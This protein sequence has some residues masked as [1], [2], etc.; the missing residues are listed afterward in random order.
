[1]RPSRSP[2]ER[3]SV[4]QGVEERGG[5]RAVRDAL[6]RRP[7]V[8]QDVRADEARCACEEPF[9]QV[10]LLDGAEARGGSQGGSHP[11]HLYVLPVQ[12]GSRT[13][14]LRLLERRAM[15]VGPGAAAQAVG[16]LH[17]MCSPRSGGW[18]E[19]NREG[20]AGGR[21]PPLI[22]SPSRDSA[23]A[24]SQGLIRTLRAGHT[25]EGA[26]FAVATPFIRQVGGSCGFPTAG[27]PGRLGQRDG[28][29]RR[30]RGRRDV[31]PARRGGGR[32]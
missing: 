12:G 14:G 11:R 27:G 26:R 25:P 21:L 31:R 24:K 29:A 1:M 9:R 6:P 15:R 10:R 22:R 23:G 8:R 5:A 28:R 17:G 20:V 3:G 4:V 32:T 7:R 13:R 18:G 19:R 16:V 2:R 30:S